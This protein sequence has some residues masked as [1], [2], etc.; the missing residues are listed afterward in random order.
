MANSILNTLGVG[1]GMD[2][3]AIIEALV[4]AEKAPQES[5]INKRIS[6]SEATISG[7]GTLTSALSTLKD[8]LSSLADASEIESSVNVNSSADEFFV[9]SADSPAPGSY[10]VQVTQLAIGDQ[11]TAELGEPD[12]ELNGGTDFDIDVTFGSPSTTTTVTVTDTT[13]AGV[14]DALNAADLPLTARIVDTG[15]DSVPSKRYKVLLTGDV[16]ADNAM[17]I[18]SSVASFA[19]PQTA[20]DARLVVDGITMIRSSNTFSDVVP[21]MTITAIETQAAASTI[22]VVRNDEAVVTAVQNFVDTFNSFNEVASAL[23][24]PDSSLDGGGT[25]ASDSTLRSIVNKMRNMVLDESSVTSGDVTHFSSLGVSF[26]RSGTLEL[27]S[28]VLRSALTSNLTD[29]VTALSADR[30]ADSASNDD[31]K[32]LAG[33][34]VQYIEDLTDDDGLIENRL[35]TAEDQIDRYQDDL[36]ALEDKMV[37]IEERYVAQFT[38][39][40]QAVDRFESLRESLKSQ[41]ENMPFSNSGD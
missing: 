23:A 5:Q 18:T 14:V 24:D 38:A 12:D 4:N 29:V 11:F 10:S 21:G 34:L 6:S 20:T 13:P 15:D 3:G 8:S 25:L 35:N 26:T 32:G 7:F 31:P 16:G 41:F 17:T 28:D 37:R 30:T 39:M 36:K 19:K 40:E 22:Q 1:S 9:S 27:D 33:D 2:T